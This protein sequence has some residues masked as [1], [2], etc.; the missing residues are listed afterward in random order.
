[1]AIECDLAVVGSGPG[2][3]VA[4][5]RA[6]Q[7][8][9]RVVLVEKESLGGTCLNW[10]CI[11]SKALLESAGRMVSA[12]EMAQYGVDVAGVTA[13][14]AQVQ[15]RKDQVVRTLRNGVQGLLRGN[16]ITLVQGTGSFL[17]PRHLRVQKPDGGVEDVTAKNVVVATGSV[18]ARPPIPGIDLPGIMTSKEA[19]GIPEIPESI[20][21]VGGGYIGVEFATIFRAF[22]SQVTVVEMLSGLVPLEDAEIGRALATSYQ[23]QGIGVKTGTRVTRIAQTERGYSL[24]L[25]ADGGEETLEAQKVLVAVGRWPYTE[26]LGLERI[27]AA[28][29][30]RAI[31]VDSRMRTNVPG[32]YAIGDVVAK[33]PLA[34]VA[35]MQGEVAAENALGHDAE[36]DYRAVPNCIFCSPQ[37]ASVGLS[38]EQARQKGYGVKVGRFPFVAASKAVAAGHA[39]GLIKVVAEERYGQVL[40]VHMIGPEVTDLIGEAVVAINLETSVEDFA[41]TMHAH[42]TLPEALREAVLDVEGRAIHILRRRR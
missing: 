28:M 19:L 31:A 25:A 10:G 3:Y 12:R 32:V 16:G 1:M 37:V 17:D 13:N 42:P 6:A 18:E 4:A 34:H 27:G 2:G 21:I 14:W 7:L 23:K 39:E 36:M 40:G 11:P 9:A 22:G 5:I 20:A 35:S 8:G 30:R 15:A 29:D 24:S 26:G 41:K 38:E 33:Y